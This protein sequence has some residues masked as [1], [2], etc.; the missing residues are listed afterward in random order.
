MR[1]KSIKDWRLWIK[2]WA[3]ERGGIMLVENKKTD[4]VRQRRAAEDEMRQDKIPWRISL[5]DAQWQQK[6]APSC[7]ASQPVNSA[8]TCGFPLHHL[9]ISIV[10]E[11]SEG[12]K[13]SI[14]S[15]HK[16]WHCPLSL[17]VCVCVWTQCKR[18]HSG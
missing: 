13:R 11:V 14:I 4:K 5:C 18:G 9:W 1:H 7:Q 17:F 12:G 8:H 3:K 10:L 2:R 15:Q 16:D 6:E